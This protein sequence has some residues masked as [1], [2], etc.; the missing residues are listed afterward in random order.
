VPISDQ[1]LPANHAN[2]AKS[3]G[4]CT[5]DG[6][7][8]SARNSRAQGFTAS[9]FAVVRLED[10]TEVTHLKDDLTAVYHPVKS[11]T[12]V[13]RW[14]NS[15]VSSRCDLNYETN[16]FWRSNPKKTNLVMPRR[17]NPFHPSNHPA[18]RVASR[19]LRPQGEISI[20][21]IF[22]SAWNASYATVFARFHMA[23]ACFLPKHKVA[24]RKSA[25]PTGIASAHC[26]SRWW[27]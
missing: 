7:A 20:E 26:C 17:T 14:R 12:T 15:T 16:P 10:L 25:C 13:E 19:L 1:Q 8:R 5:P 21:N 24:C 11:A 4:P 27:W 22:R 9:T 2:A 23:N 3:T 6:K 18:R